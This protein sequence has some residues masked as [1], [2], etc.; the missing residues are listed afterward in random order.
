MCE[1]SIIRAFGDKSV[2]PCSH[3]TK[4]SPIFTARKRSLGQG[5]IFIG[6]CQEFCWGGFGAVSAPGGVCF[7][8]VSALVGC[9]LPGGLLPG[10]CLLPGVCSRGCL[11][12]GGVC[13]RGVSALWVSSPGG[14]PGGHP[15]GTATAAGGTHPTGM[16]SCFT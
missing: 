9:L 5:N 16:H 12:L 2:K 1:H 14:V 8:G 11:L 4:F 6:V 15:P 10:G 7:Q 13:S 3:I